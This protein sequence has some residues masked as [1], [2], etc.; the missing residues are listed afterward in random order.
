M[1]RLD[2]IYAEKRLPGGSIS[3]TTLRFLYELLGAREPHVNISHREMPT[4]RQHRDFVESC[5]YANWWLVMLER[6]DG[7]ERIGATYLTDL[8]E[9]GIHLVPWAAG[10][11]YGSIVVE[12]I[13]RRHPGRR[14][15]ANIAPSNEA[16]IALFAKFGFQ[17]I[18]NTYSREP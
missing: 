7:A 12:E 16:S 17:H 10:K 5:P 4:F 13:I 15:L 14:F 1:I 11:G 18:Q 3:E 8:N 6:G 9:I 2:S